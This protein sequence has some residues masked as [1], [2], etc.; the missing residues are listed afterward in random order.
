MRASRFGGLGLG[1]ALA[2]A[3]GAVG[4]GNGGNGL[5][6]S[7]AALSA[8]EEDSIA[9]MRQ[10]EKLARDVYTALSDW[11]IPF[12]RIRNAEQMHMD[13]MAT[14]IGRHGLADPVA[15]LAIGDFAD[16]EMQGLHDALVEQGR[17]SFVAA[18]RAGAEI[19]ELDIADL[20]AASAETSHTDVAN[21]Y[22]NLE[23]GSRN[24]L[25][26][27]A[28]QLAAQGE[29]YEPTHLDAASYDAIVSS[30]HE[31]GGPSA[32]GGACHGNCSGQ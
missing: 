5:S 15:G 3:L 31:R 7:Q 9:Q 6:T 17:T 12:T 4:C 30:P 23:R 25:R 8:P 11:G 29:S 16:T 13:A 18:L 20:R 19:E 1:L 2:L 21:T 28:A 24:H 26:A 14:L 32:G 10:E 27:F 22:A